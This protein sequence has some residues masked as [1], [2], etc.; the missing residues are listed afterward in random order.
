MGKTLQAFFM[1]ALSA[2]RVLLASTH[3]IRAQRG[4]ED[5]DLRAGER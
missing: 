3:F 4:N 1:S 5:S 2:Q